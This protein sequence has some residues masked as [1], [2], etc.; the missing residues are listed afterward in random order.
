MTCYVSDVV[1]G[2]LIGGTVAHMLH[3]A[4]PYLISALTPVVRWARRRHLA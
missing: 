1:A 2:A 3:L 4:K